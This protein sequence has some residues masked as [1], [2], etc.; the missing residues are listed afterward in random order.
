MGRRENEPNNEKWRGKIEI[1][2]E[3]YSSWLVET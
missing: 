2:T 1:G 3:R